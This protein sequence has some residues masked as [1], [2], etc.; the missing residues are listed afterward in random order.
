[1]NPP[2]W[3]ELER[4]YRAACQTLEDPPGAVHLMGIG[5]VGMAGLAVL[6][7]ARGHAVTGCDVQRSRV[8][9]RLQAMGI[10]VSIGH[11]PSHLTGSE[12]MIVR[13]P[14]V[15][16]EESEW[17]AACAAQSKS[18][19]RGVVLAALLRGRSSVAIAGTHGKTTT[20]AMLTHIL[21]ANARPLSF[22]IGGE[23]DD[24]GG[25]AS[26]STQGPLVVEADESDG[27]LAL[28][29]PTHAVITNVELDHVDFFS[30]LDALDACFRRFA[31][32]TRGTLWYCG[33]DAG[34]TRAARERPN[35]RAFGFAAD[36]DLRAHSYAAQ[37]IG[38][39]ASVFWQGRALGELALPVPGRTNVV[40]ALGAMGAAHALGVEW[41]D[42]IRALASF[43]PVRRRF[44]MLLRNERATVISDYAH[45]PT[46]IRAL[47]AQVRSLAPRRVVAIFQPHRYSRTA[48]LGPDFPSAFD[49]ADRIVLAPVYAASE[50]PV[51][52]G[53]HRDLAGHF[54]AQQRPVEIAE[55]LLEAW[56]LIRHNWR[57]GDVL[58]VIGAGDVEKIA[59]WAAEEFN[60]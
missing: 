3:S 51:P 30:S 9:A 59:V 19:S 10:G 7:R 27:T 50:S 39:R 22:A 34:A 12:Q 42:S 23:I 20:T 13:S 24:S 28:Y 40:D 53:T 8:T 37:G 60:A 32:R 47:F 48:A 26:A 18:F 49:G 21:R 33:D 1:M 11:A 16:D 44:E 17:Q 14:A 35:A 29:E 4:A 46:E 25:V 5:G 45:H 58:L 38:T 31:E 2:F 52:G 56:E 43:A 57:T 41:M 55:S 6:L 54:I 36:C 15:R